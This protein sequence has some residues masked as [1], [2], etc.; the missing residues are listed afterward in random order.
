MN[1]KN[2]KLTYFGIT[3]GRGETCRMALSL[4]NIPFDDDRVSF[5]EWKKLKTTTPWGSLPLLTLA[6]GTQVGQQRAILRLIGKE[7]GLYPADNLLAAKVDSLMDGTEDLFP[8]TN[9]VGQGLP[10]AEK[11]AARKAAAEKGGEVYGLLER[12][13]SYIGIHGAGGHAVGDSFTIA[14][15]FVYVITSNIVSGLFDGIPSSALD[16]FENVKAVRKTVRSHPGVVKYFD[17][18]PD[19][20]KA[21]VPASFQALV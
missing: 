7:T 20:I 16:D 3:G 1:L 15:L 4:G 8:K 13:D 5:P 18:L 2:C 19:D 6:D 14:D 21:N 12:I 10:Q 17:N 11:E 9:A